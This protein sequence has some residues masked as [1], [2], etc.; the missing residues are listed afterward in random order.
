MHTRHASLLVALLVV[1]AG[2]TTEES[3]IGSIVYTPDLVVTQTE[4]ID[5]P[6]DI[7]GSPQ[8]FP[9]VLVTVRNRGDGTAH[10]SYVEL[11]IKQGG[12]I[13]ETARGSF[14]RV[15]PGQ[16][17]QAEVTLSRVERHA[18]YDAM[19]C[20]LHWLDARGRGGDRSC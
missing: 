13:I 20:R 11:R 19:D 1:F 8:G 18:D 3:L 5:P 12:T 16:Q 15:D 17:V 7:T 4:R 6:N 2:C 14:A 9:T 10:N